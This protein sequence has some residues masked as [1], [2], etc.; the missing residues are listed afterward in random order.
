M[1]SALRFI[2]AEWFRGSV[3][4]HA[5][6][7]L[8]RLQRE[9]ARTRPLTSPS[10]SS[11][12]HIQIQNQLA[13]FNVDS[14]RIHHI[15]CW[16]RYGQ[17]KSCEQILWRRLLPASKSIYCHWGP[18]SLFF[19]GCWEIKWPGCEADHSLLLSTVG[20]MKEQTSFCI[21]TCI[22]MERTRNTLLLYWV[23]L[24]NFF[25]TSLALRIC[26]CINTKALWLLIYTL[27]VW[28][29]FTLTLVVMFHI[30]T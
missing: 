16:L 29:S 22:F 30:S 20:I 11:R 10:P 26:S 12:L 4:K 8:A 23:G 21:L 18:T 24:L 27:L 19:N 1:P 15:P 5:S 6:Y 7:F 25:A 17:P 28:S 3:C 9:V 13:Q 2:K 14:C